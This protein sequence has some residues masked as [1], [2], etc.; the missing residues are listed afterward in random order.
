MLLRAAQKC[1]SICSTLLAIRTR[2]SDEDPIE[3]LWYAATNMS[4]L[5]N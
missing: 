3:R 2:I 5:H 1:S 4:M